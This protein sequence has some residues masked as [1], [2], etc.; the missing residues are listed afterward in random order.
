M[1]LEL[2]NQG[3]AKTYVKI[4]RRLTR[5]IYAFFFKLLAVKKDLDP[6]RVKKPFLDVSSP[7]QTYNQG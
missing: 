7:F 4:R 6:G 2:A 3:K 5:Q 1:E